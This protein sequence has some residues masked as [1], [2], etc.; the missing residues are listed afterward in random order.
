MYTCNGI[1]YLGV[2]P[3]AFCCMKK[4]A[5]TDGT[6][7]ADIGT[8]QDGSG[9]WVEEEREKGRETKGQ[10]LLPGEQRTERA[11]S[12]INRTERKTQNKIA[13]KREVHINN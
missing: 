13:Q 11:L 9:G 7:M 12:S 1:E 4:T 6:A 5:L 3:R 2:C 10:G 8:T